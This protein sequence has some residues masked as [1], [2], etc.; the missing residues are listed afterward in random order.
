MFLK[1]KH[2]NSVSFGKIGEDIASRFLQKCGYSIIEKNYTGAGAEIDII[3]VTDDTVVFVEVKRRLNE[4]FGSPACA[5]NRKK[6]KQ[7]VK[8]A[9]CF[10]REY[11]MYDSHFRFDVIAIIGDDDISHY[12]GAFVL[13]V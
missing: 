3:A 8:A 4:D 13:P 7:L 6:Q 5:V 9:R 11:N 1:K 2:K 10:Q 12:E